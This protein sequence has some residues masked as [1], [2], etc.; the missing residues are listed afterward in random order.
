MSVLIDDRGRLWPTISAHLATRIQRL[1]GSSDGAIAAVRWLGYIQ[2]EPVGRSVIV[3][4]RPELLTAA[5]LAGAF[6]AIVRIGPDRIAL[7]YGRSGEPPEL[8][9]DI[10]R[11]LE[12]IEALSD[13]C[14]LPARRPGVVAER[15]PLDRAQ[16]LAGGR[17]AELLRNWS[18]RPCCTFHELQGRLRRIGLLSQA[19]LVRT[20]PDADSFLIEHWGSKRT[21]LGRSWARS[22]RGRDVREQPYPKLTEWVLETFRGTLAAQQP[23]LDDVNATIVTPQGAI[24]QRHYYRLLVPFRTLGDETVSAV[25]NIFEASAAP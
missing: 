1:T 24:H 3:V 18:A 23:R 7:S 10:G 14:R 16:A 15:L 13:A 6:G 22:A 19:L 20:P 21:L 12:R 5:T 4:F 11:A 8:F 9:T 2:I 25:I 17:A